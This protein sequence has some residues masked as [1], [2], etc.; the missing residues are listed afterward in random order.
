[1]LKDLGM[2][3]AAAARLAASYAPTLPMERW[4]A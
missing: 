1:V 3:S 2:E 4:K